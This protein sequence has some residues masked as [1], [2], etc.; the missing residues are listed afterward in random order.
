M[1]DTEDIFYRMESAVSHLSREDALNVLEKS[2]Y[3]LVT[4]FE[5][6]RDREVDNEDL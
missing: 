1:L 3:D 4:R 6:E 5:Q 2:V